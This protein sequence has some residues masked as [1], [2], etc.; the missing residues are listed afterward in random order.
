MTA[1][2][3]GRQF[4]RLILAALQKQHRQPQLGVDGLDVA[5]FSRGAPESAV[6]FCVLPHGSTIT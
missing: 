4:A 2:E 3:I 5:P 6:R 1:Q